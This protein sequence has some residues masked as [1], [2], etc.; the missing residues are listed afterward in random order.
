MAEECTPKVGGLEGRGHALAHGLPQRVR[1]V[2]RE[3]APLGRRPGGLA[4]QAVSVH[5]LHMHGCKA[6]TTQVCF[7]RS[8]ALTALRPGERVSSDVCGSCFLNSPGLGTILRTCVRFF[9]T[10]C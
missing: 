1:C 6:V 5:G 10:V 9:A 2:L 3:E 8:G 4:K 7:P